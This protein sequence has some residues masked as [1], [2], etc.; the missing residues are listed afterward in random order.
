LGEW[1]ERKGAQ[2]REQVWIPH[3]RP[4]RGWTAGAQ[5]GRGRCS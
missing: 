2:A 3:A 5:T 4:I 1:G